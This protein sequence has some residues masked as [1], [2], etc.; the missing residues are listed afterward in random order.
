MGP[1][2]LLLAAD[3]RLDALARC[4]TIADDRARLECFDRDA[5][6]LL[7]AVA[8][9]DAALV[10]RDAQ[11]DVAPPPMQALDTTLA[12]SVRRGDD[13]WTLRLADGSRWE[14][15]AWYVTRTLKPGTAVSIRR[16]SLGSYVVRVPGERSVR[17]RRL[18]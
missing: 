6:A 15:E 4:I 14:T 12:A 2:F 5:H 17:A 1:L 11:V 8:R 13:H 7:G 10:V 3:V 18:G 9:G 16:G